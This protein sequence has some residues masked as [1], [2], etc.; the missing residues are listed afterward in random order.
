MSEVQCAV[1]CAVLS[2][3]DLSLRESAEDS[4]HYNDAMRA[5]S[6]CRLYGIIDLGYIQPSDAARVVEQMIE[7]GVDLIQLR[8]K[9]SN[10]RTG[11]SG[12]GAT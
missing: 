5:L 8:G 12:S 10:Q 9:T 11:R 3:S 6:D 2:A 1:A 7:G 4:G